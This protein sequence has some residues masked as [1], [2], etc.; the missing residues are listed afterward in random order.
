MLTNGAS[1]SHCTSIKECL[2]SIVNRLLQSYFKEAD[3]KQWQPRIDAFA[4]VWLSSGSG[5][6]P[7]LWRYRSQGSGRQGHRFLCEVSEVRTIS[8]KTAFMFFHSFFNTSPSSGKSLR[9][10]SREKKRVELTQTALPVGDF[11]SD[12]QAGLPLTGSIDVRFFSLDPS[13]KG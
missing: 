1:Y 8:K 10:H 13:T 5:R 4:D 11:Y 9:A 2:G 12:L 7:L 6:S 3:N